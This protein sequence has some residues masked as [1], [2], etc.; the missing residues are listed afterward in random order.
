MFRNHGMN[1]CKKLCKLISLVDKKI[2]LIEN[3]KDTGCTS[4]KNV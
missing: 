4:H 3:I 2:K 1:Y